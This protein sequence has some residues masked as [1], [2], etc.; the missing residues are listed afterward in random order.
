MSSATVLDHGN[1]DEIV[2]E[3]AIPD[4][5]AVPLDELSSDGDACLIVDDILRVA[6]APGRVKVAAFNSAL[7]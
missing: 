3:S 1:A 5:S 4:I 6:A 7:T 2:V